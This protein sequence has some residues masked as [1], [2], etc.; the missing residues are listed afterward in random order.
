MIDPVEEERIVSFL[1]GLVSLY[2]DNGVV[3]TQDYDDCPYFT[4]GD[5]EI[6]FQNY[7]GEGFITHFPR[8]DEEARE[9]VNELGEELFGPDIVMKTYNPDADKVL[10]A[11]PVRYDLKCKVS[12]AGI[13]YTI[14]AHAYNEDLDHYE[15]REKAVSIKELFDDNG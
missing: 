8:L 2:E 4:V 13:E 3:A 14:V 5:S 9:R 11:T 12:P 6:Y 15:P 1:R 7:D 10:D